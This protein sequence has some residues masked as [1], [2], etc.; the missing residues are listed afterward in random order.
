ML[1][2]GLAI[3][4]EPVVALSPVPGDHEYEFAPLADNVAD[5]PL[6]TNPSFTVIVGSGFTVTET[7][8]DVA[9]QPFTSVTVTE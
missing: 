4:V 6:Q 3:T 5:P 2:A 9:E 8:E 7:T 1:P